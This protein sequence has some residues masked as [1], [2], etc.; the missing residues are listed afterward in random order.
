MK[1]WLLAFAAA[2]IALIFFVFRWYQSIHAAEWQEEQEAVRTAKER[3]GLG[4]IERIAT[5]NEDQP[6]TVVFGVYGE[7]RPMVVWVGPNDVHAE[8]AVSAATENQIR[9]KVLE[10]MPGCEILRIVP[11]KQENAYVWEAFYKIMENGKERY[12]YDYY[13]F[14][15]GAYIDTYTL[16]IR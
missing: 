2:L 4:K 9:S 15:D 1:K 11:G 5:F 7:D 13:Q 10:R 14:K 12:Y 8:D 3:F 16:S 6:Y